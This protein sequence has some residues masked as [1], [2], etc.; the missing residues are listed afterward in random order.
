MED[1]SKWFKDET[2]DCLL[3]GEELDIRISTKGK[4]YVVCDACG[5]QLFVRGAEGIK[6]LKK[7]VKSWW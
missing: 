5:I 2:F 7:K 3:C 1:Y 4:P 6:R